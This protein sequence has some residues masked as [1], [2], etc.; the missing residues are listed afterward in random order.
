[1]SE[2]NL[3]LKKNK[4][5]KNPLRYCEVVA[6]TASCCRSSKWNMHWSLILARIDSLYT[7]SSMGFWPNFTLLSKD[8]KI[9]FRKK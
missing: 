2:I 9:L 8:A 7:T 4:Q 1:M 5:K 3:K 6:P